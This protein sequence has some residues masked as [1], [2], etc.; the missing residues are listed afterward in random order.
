M[1]EEMTM[2]PIVPFLQ[3]LSDFQKLSPC[4]FHIFIDLNI[5]L[6]YLRSIRKDSIIYRLFIE[7]TEMLIFNY[8]S[9][10]PNTLLVVCFT[11]LVGWRIESQFT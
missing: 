4:A 5:I 10:I 9:H 7:K 3:V 8:L 11:L 1:I 6:S 2:V